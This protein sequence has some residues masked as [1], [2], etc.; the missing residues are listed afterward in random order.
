M[1][2]VVL[3]ANFA[4]YTGGESELELEAES[5]R[6]LLRCLG[7]R[8]PALAPHLEQGLAVAVD[9]QIYQEDWFQPLAPDSEVHLLPQ[10]AGG[11]DAC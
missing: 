5:I 9:G 3:T 4:L 7:Q 8:F 1:A 6:Q 10:I 11:S 2:R